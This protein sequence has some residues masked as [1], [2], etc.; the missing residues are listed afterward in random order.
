MNVEKQL[1]Q[2]F[3]A[4]PLPETDLAE[5]VLRQAE[6]PAGFLATARGRRRAV[7]AICALVLVF[8]TVALATQLGI[9]VV[10]LQESYKRGSFQVST[11]EAVRIPPE[12]FAERYIARLD[13][14]FK[15]EGYSLHT[16]RFDTL[17]EALEFWDVPRM[18]NKALDG[19]SGDTSAFIHGFFLDGQLVRTGLFTRHYLPRERFPDERLPIYMT[20]SYVTPEQ[21]NF[22]VG[23]EMA[24][25]PDP[26]NSEA[27]VVVRSNSY[28]S[29]VNG[30]TAIH[31]V[32]YATHEKH[33]LY[34]ISYN[35]LALLDS[36]LIYWII[37]QCSQKVDSDEVAQYILDGFVRL[38]APTSDQN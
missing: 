8:G 31:S 33:R 14:P 27:K 29:A 9:D 22:I 17:E 23:N 24:F 20:S 13:K 34:P 10:F 2:A 16:L 7:W 26:D 19:P 6:R 35:T 3:A 12:G 28:T 36:D 21:G 25:Y 1:R 11:E 38:D 30:L 15:T 32:A 4:L 37:F 18:E 5:R